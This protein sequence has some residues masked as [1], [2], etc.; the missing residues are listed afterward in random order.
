MR[1][2]E[3]AYP[4]RGKARALTGKA[5]KVWRTQGLL[6][7]V[8]KLSRFALQRMSHGAEVVRYAFPPIRA[9]DSAAAQ[10]NTEVE[11]IEPDP[12][13]DRDFF[14]GP[15]VGDLPRRVA[16]RRFVRSWRTHGPSRK[17]FAGFHPGIYADRFGLLQDS[18]RPNPLSHYILHGK[19]HGPWSPYLIR[20]L[21]RPG[22][23][24]KLR[25][26]LHIHAHYPEL[27]PE[28]LARVAVNSARCDLVVTLSEA[29]KEA[30]ATIPLPVQPNPSIVFHVVPN[31][32]RNLG[33]FAHILERLQAYDVVGHVHTKKSPDSDRRVVDVWREFLLANMVGKPHP[34]ID[35]ILGG[36]E[37]DPKLGIVFPNDPHLTGWTKNL[38]PATEL[39][40]RLNIKLALP[41]AFD[42]PNGAMFWVRPAALAPLLNAKIAW[43]EYPPEP[44]PY[45]GTLLHALERLL[46]FIVSHEGYQSA[47]TNV[48]GVLR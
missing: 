38:G 4:P 15:G 5:W 40:R 19:P 44:V 20:P 41:Q 32:G 33:A 3:P 9:I 11:V 35:A 30:L 36:F 16:I 25:S 1:I 23:P 27:L 8:W 22:K 28:I 37:A 6:R 21:A 18:R 31:I 26:A 47:M 13:F 34:M 43:E 14:L 10:A 7:L 39:L 48:P 46:P 29:S 17:P 12:D 2:R 45:D 42:F 24:S